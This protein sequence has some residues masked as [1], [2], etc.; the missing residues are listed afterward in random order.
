VSNGSVNTAPVAEHES[1]DQNGK[2]TAGI[3]IA[4]AFFVGAPIL[5]ISA[6]LT[7][8]LFSYMHIRRSVIALGL[9]IYSVIAVFFVVPLVNLFIESWTKVFPEILSHKLTVGSGILSMLGHQVFLSLPLGVAVG[10]IY[11]TWRWMTRPVWDQVVFR[12]TPWE[13]YF[14]NKNIR[15]IESD[16][17]G[18][19]NGTTLGVTEFGKKIVQTDKEAS[20]HTLVVGASGSG[21]T[22]TLMSKARDSIRRGQ[23]V[24]FID[25]KGG[26]DVPDILSQF[27]KRY[28]RKFTHWLM[29]SRTE[30][31]TGPSPDGPAYYDPLARGDATRRKDLLI[32]SRNWSEEHYKIQASSYLQMLFAVL[33]GNPKK[34]ASTF[35]DVVSLLDPTYLQERATVLGSNPAYHD[36]VAGIDALNDTKI[37]AT[38]LSAIEGLK[39][40]LE[41][42][43]HSIAGHWLQVD[44]VHDHNINLKKAAHSGEI[45]VFSLDSA[46]YQ[47]LSALVANLIIQDL[48]TVTSEL[49]DD[50]TSKPFQVFIDEFSAIGSDNI[51]GLINKS[52]DANMPV[53]LS[54]QALGDLRKVDATFL[55]QVLGIINSFVIHR[56]NTEEDAKVYAGLTGTVWRKK[57][58]QSVEHTT[59]RFGLGK[60]SGTGSGTVEDV[61]EF[62]VG[63][64]EVQELATGEIVYVTKSPLRIEHVLVIPE[65]DV[66]TG[67]GQE[68]SHVRTTEIDI[69]A[70]Q[71]L[72]TVPILAQTGDEIIDNEENPAMATPYQD[73]FQRTEMDYSRQ[74][75]PERLKKILNRDDTAVLKETAGNNFSKVNLP[76]I[77]PT[78]P[79]RPTAPVPVPVVAETVAEKFTPVTVLPAFPPKFPVKPDETVPVEEEKPVESKPIQPSTPKPPRKDEFEF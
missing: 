19:L 76:K 44:T 7:W 33:I 18:P 60:G 34:N 72:F 37:S 62:R 2:N 38:K 53:T 48:K 56:A 15:D 43:L 74:S 69:K 8:F 54:T 42:I 6:V 24:V 11:A 78:L 51:I 77:S 39:S 23:G 71:S 67:Y 58:R 21:K 35:S 29:Q 46:N 57:F 70:N 27:A 36:I 1:E 20:A 31:Y 4:V 68:K 28:D 79:S 9:A 5:A 14:R 40:Q 66:S 3:L 17:N 25:L 64:S 41:V 13:L 49:R 16:Q 12:R 22:T 50:P 75:D 45:I 65:T 32:A 26:G 61:E 30:E 55:D 63:P 47:E 73:D 59:S 10:L 52:R